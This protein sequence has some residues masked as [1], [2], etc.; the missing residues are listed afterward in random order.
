MPLGL[1]PHIMT[2][3]HPAVGAHTEH[4]SHGRDTLKF[5]NFTIKNAISSNQFSTWFHKSHCTPQIFYVESSK[6]EYLNTHLHWNFF[7]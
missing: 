3:E 4:P 5:G 2:T 7:L 6:F 1:T